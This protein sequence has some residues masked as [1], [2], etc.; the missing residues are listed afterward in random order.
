MSGNA[1]DT[2]TLF[3]GEVVEG[4]SRADGAWH[5]T[6]AAA[7]AEAGDAVTRGHLAKVRTALQVQ[8]RAPRVRE[9]HTLEQAGHSFSGTCPDAAASRW[10]RS[11]AHAARLTP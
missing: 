4:W 11:S 9:L 8:E 7:P 3:T 6:T 5:R 10:R 2:V 1:L